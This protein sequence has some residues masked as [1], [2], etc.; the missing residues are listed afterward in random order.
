MYNIFIL[1]NL[2]PM[3]NTKV[4]NPKEVGRHKKQ[5]NWQKCA[6]KCQ[7]NSK[8]KIWSYKE[9]TKT[10]Y[11]FSKYTGLFDA[12]LFTTGLSNCTKGK[13]V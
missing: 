4:E 5:K 2:C 7:Q 11:L 1:G 8:C 12:E 10:C 13:G 6:G 9:N 3:E